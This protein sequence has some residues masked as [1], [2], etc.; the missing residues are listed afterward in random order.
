MQ[1]STQKTLNLEIE[2]DEKH[3]KLSEPKT[4]SQI[5]QTPLTKSKNPKPSKE[6]NFFF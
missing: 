4:K 5:S 6:E 2:K 1:Y 3:Q